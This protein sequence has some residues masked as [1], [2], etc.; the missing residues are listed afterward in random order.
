MQREQQ[1]D[2]WW[3][4]NT[5]AVAQKERPYSRRYVGFMLLT[6]A[7][8]RDCVAIP[9]SIESGRIADKQIAVAALDPRD[10]P[11]R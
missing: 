4:I 9:V 6:D 8:G 2:R 1:M 11:R 10:C 5:V 7:L 3:A